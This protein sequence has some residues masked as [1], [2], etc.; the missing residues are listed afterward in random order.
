MIQAAEA[1]EHAHSM[2]V[3]H[4]DV[5]P[6]NLMVDAAG[7][8]WVTDFGLAKFGADGTLTMSGDLL[9][10]LR[11]MSPEQAMARHGLVD[12]RTD[13]YALG[14]VLYELLTGRPVITGEDK[15][16]MLR[17]IA[18]E[19]PIAPR[20]INAEIPVDLETIVLSAIQK[21][22][23]ERYANAQDLAEDIRRWI[24]Q[25]PLKAKR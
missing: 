20:K 11:Y 1:L 18:F 13:V 5:K 15:Q 7:K 21:N 4:S 10:T 25:K 6:G 2:G 3:V 19:E 23:S 17:Q 12:H 9:G 8:L 24:D 16:E 14:A 22:P